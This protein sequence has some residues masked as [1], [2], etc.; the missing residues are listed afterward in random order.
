MQRRSIPAI[1]EEIGA[2]L[3]IEGDNPFRAKAYYN[4]A[5]VVAGL[6]DLDSLVKEGRLREIKG[7]GETLSANISE[8]YETGKM[9]YHEELTGRIPP[10][11]IELLQISS[12][13]PRKIKLLFEKL[14]VTGL[15]ELEYACRENRL[16]GL[17]RFGERTQSRILKGIEFLRRHKGEYL[18]G[19]VYPLAVRM[20]ER[21][22]RIVPDG[23]V[24][25]CG[26]IRR[27]KEVVRNIDIVVCAEDR[28]GVADHLASLPDVEEVFTS[29]GTRI[30]CR[31]VFGIE[32]DLRI[33]DRQ[34]F[35]FAFLYF[36]GSS[37]HTSRL[38]DLAARRGLSLDEKGLFE[39]GRPVGLAGEAEIYEFLGLSYVPPELRED[40]GELE[41]AAN[42]SLPRLVELAD[43]KGTL[44]VHTSMSDGTA[45][46]ETIAKT[47]RRM[48][49]SY[50][51]ICDHSKSAYYAGGLKGEDV[52]RQWEAIDEF[53]AGSDGFIFLKG[54]E[55]D[56]LPDGSLDY[57]DDILAGFDFVVASVHSGFSMG[58]QEMEAR[59]IRAMENP[60]TT[61]LGHPTGRLLLAREGYRVDMG[62]IIDEAARLHVMIELNAS[63]YRLDI[64]WRRLPEA[65]AKGVM[66]A[67]NPDA[68]SAE[69]IAEIF[70]GIGIARKGW[71]TAGDV[72]NTRDAQGVMDLFREVKDGKGS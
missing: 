5:K 8:Y 27:K 9:A 7:I 70:F 68:H 1:L 15:G 60:Y 13:G 63:P 10:T 51:G 21:L 72:V 30:S 57:G 49:L 47:A 37:E 11:L 40:M 17:F 46:L 24:E 67:V 33:V 50:V 32:A 65:R 16:V 43:L 58:Q 26:S 52:L 61:I 55:S 54:I 18:F 34:S 23:L 45:N 59:I 19:E 22:A 71:L 66:I 42:R 20:K 48:G 56:I 2:L 41:A 35:P 25:I 38:R 53:N 39:A 62:R 6:D 12:L 14:G 29:D 28:R 31:L 44:H 4:A 36:T 69:G 64:D 3:E